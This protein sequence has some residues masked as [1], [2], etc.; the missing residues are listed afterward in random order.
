MFEEANRTDAGW[1]VQNRWGDGMFLP[2]DE[3]QASVRVGLLGTRAVGKFRNKCVALGQLLSSLNRPLYVLD[4]RRDGCGGQGSWSPREFATE[5]PSMMAG[6][7]RYAFVHLPS[8]APSIELLAWWRSS[9]PAWQDFRMRYDAELSAGGVRVAAAFVESASTRGGLAV[10]VCAERDAED[11]DSLSQPEQ[12][13]LYCHRFTLA[14]RV[15]AELNG[16][17]PNRKSDI[18]RLSLDGMIPPLRP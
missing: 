10:M 15:L 8:V 6:Q 12:D 16:R 18:I 11:F 9:K 7:R 4:T 17:R 13:N 5:I 1:I 14:R 2:V 3:T